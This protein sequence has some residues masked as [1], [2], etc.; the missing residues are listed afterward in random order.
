M[1]L[2]FTVKNYRSYK[3][4]T[5]FSMEANASEYKKENV[6]EFD[7]FRV[8]KCA[9]IYGPNASGKT[10]L[11]RAIYFLRTLIL[12]QR[13]AG[14]KLPI[15][16]PFLFDSKEKDNPLMFNIE[17]MGPQNHRYIY[18]IVLD[19]S[20]ILEEELLIYSKGEKVNLFKRNKFDKKSIIQTGVINSNNKTINVFSNQLIL[21]KFGFEEP[22]EILTPIFLYFEKFVV[23][24]A[25]NDRHKEF[26]FDEM[27]KLLT[28]ESDIKSM[29]KKLIKAADTKVIGFEVVKNSDSEKEDSFRVFGIHDFYTNNKITGSK[30][31]SINEESKGTQSLYIFGAQILKTLEK[32]NFYLIFNQNISQFIEII[33]FSSFAFTNNKHCFL[34]LSHFHQK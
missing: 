6:V 21:T 11:I 17:F 32:G 4:E 2:K 26:L 10:N 23:L 1:I 28:E 34:K 30:K 25:T 20:N 5:T 9:M 8:L 7:N 13:K 29:L 16:D 3:D 18:K 14:E 24:N 27:S 15:Y 19:Q 22:D 31:L 33:G 12:S